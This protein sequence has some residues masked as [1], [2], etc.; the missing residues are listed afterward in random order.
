MKYFFISPRMLFFDLKL[1]SL[2]CQ[3]SASQQKETAYEFWQI[4]FFVGGGVKMP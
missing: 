4:N 2:T 3:S 1:F